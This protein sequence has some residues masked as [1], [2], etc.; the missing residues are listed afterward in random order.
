MV[1]SKRELVLGIIRKHPW[2][3]GAELGRYSGMSKNNAVL[4]AVKLVELGRAT[5]R[6]N[7]SGYVYAEVADANRSSYATALRAADLHRSI[8]RP[9]PQVDHNEPIDVPFRTVSDMKPPPRAGFARP[10]SASEP[11]NF[12]LA[13]PFYAGAVQ[14]RTPAMPGYRR[15]QEPARGTA[16]VVF[17]PSGEHFRQQAARL[18]ELERAEIEREE[19][20]RRVV[21]PPIDMVRATA[22]M[23]LDAM[24]AWGSL[25]RTPVLPAETR[26]ASYPQEPT[27]S[28]R[29]ARQSPQRSRAGAWPDDYEDD[30]EPAPAPAPTAVPVPRL[31]PPAAAPVPDTEPR[32]HFLR[33]KREP[34][35]PARREQ[36]WR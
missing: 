5:R 1:L 7:G 9:V 21:Q 19:S 24:M 13:R 28:L 3:T 20:A 34:P 29:T 2:A 25:A 36:Y 33:K 17:D 4:E 16:L 14:H 8:E 32:M 31:P 12:A 22:R 30:P 11:S 18:A 35:L 26:L 23:A 27:P 6:L 10:P 15:P